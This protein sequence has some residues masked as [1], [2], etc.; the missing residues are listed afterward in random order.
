M[1]FWHQTIYYVLLYH[2]ITALMSGPESERTI[3]CS[4]SK[5][6]APGFTWRFNHTQVIVVRSEAG[7]AHT[8]SEEW[9]QH[10]KAVSESGSLTLQG[11]SA[12]HS[13]VYTCELTNADETLVT[14]TVLQVTGGT[15]RSRNKEG[16]SAVTQ[17]L[18]T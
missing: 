11:L 3:L 18:A 1:F 8:A 13:G 6:P 2:I 12:A 16:N 4:D 5:A 7:G 17:T 15:I 10:V 9:K 14:N